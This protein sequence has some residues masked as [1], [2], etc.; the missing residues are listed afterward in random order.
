M[1]RSPR[2]DVPDVGQRRRVGRRDRIRDM[3][4][5][6]FER[7]GCGPPAHRVL[8]AAA[9]A[10]AWRISFLCSVVASSDA[11]AYHATEWRTVSTLDVH[12]GLGCAPG[13]GRYSH[14][15]H[16]AWNVPGP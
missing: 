2:T 3:K 8:A 11:T 5:V 7:L 14:V 12:E 13:I 1:T 6:P 4:T 16:R 9:A 10:S 15:T